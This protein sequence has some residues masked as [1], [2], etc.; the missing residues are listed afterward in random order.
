MSPIIAAVIVIVGTVFGIWL[1]HQ[2]QTQRED[3][4]WRQDQKVVAY[5]RFAG[6]TDAFEGARL[7][8]AGLVL[9]AA[10][11]PTKE[12]GD[13]VYQAIEALKSAVL[14][15]A[16][17]MGA[18]ELVASPLVVDAAR[19][20]REKLTGD[21]DARLDE[22]VAFQDQIRKLSD[23]G[24]TPRDI[25]ADMLDRLVQ[26]DLQDEETTWLRLARADLGFNE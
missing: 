23:E 6:S 1:G 14:D 3:R 5:Q 19:L 11:R 7:S 17:A 9:A 13:R 4:R 16:G 15:L 26:P 8:L 10:T 2:F 24:R 25:P 21:L 18:I 12:T 22:L 20:I